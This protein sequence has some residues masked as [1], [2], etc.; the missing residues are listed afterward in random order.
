MLCAI[1]PALILYSALV[2][3]ELLSGFLPM[4]A[5]WLALRDRDRHPVRGAVLSGATMGLATLVGPQAIVLAPAMGLALVRLA[6]RLEACKAVFVRGAIATAVALAVVAPW[7]LRNCKV[8][9]GCAFVSTNGGWNLAIG[10][11]A[12]ATGRFETLRASDGCEVVTGQVQQD[13][14][15]ARHG[16]D[17]IRNDPKRWLGLAPKKLDNSFNHESFA[18]E[19]I[20]TGNPSAWPEPRRTWWRARLTTFHRLLMSVAAFGLVGVMSR[21]SILQIRQ[22]PVAMRNRALVAIAIEGGLWVITAALVI[23]AWRNDAFEFW[24]LALW[25]P[26]VGFLPRP[27]APQRGAVGLFV[28]WYL[29]TFNLV[30]VVFFGEDRYHIP[31]VPLLCI[32]CAGVGR[33]SRLDQQLDV[34]ASPAARSL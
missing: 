25:M 32:L 2:M 31:L 21:R 30:H 5:L 16:W 17:A 3:T 7:T 1:H 18:I 13:R 14:C 11:F 28:A 8:M 6:P 4:L 27:G 23:Y 29:L 10:A 34:A 26:I 33:F 19:Y 9:D 24:P 22:A 20:K 12:R 15:W